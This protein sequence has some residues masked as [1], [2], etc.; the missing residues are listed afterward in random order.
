METD[1]IFIGHNNISSNDDIRISKLFGNITGAV[2]EN[3]KRMLCDRVIS[4][5]R[6]RE[7]S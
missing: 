2:S 6:K 3:A 5:R 4:E 1:I 7:T